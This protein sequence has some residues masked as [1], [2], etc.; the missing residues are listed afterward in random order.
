MN[1]IYL[2]IF[3]LIASLSACN[4]QQ[5]STDDAYTKQKTILLQAIDAKVNEQKLRLGQLDS[6]EF[7]YKKQF[8]TIAEKSAKKELQQKIVLLDS[9]KTDAQHRI[10][11]FLM[12]RSKVQQMGIHQL[13]MKK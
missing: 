12:K 9:E 2:Y 1:R 7:A 5:K 11:F 10:K 8:D 3:C 4:K 6:T 13:P